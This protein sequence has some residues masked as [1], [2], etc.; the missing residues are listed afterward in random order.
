MNEQQKIKSDFPSALLVAAR[1]GRLGEHRGR[2]IS[3]INFK[4]MPQ[5]STGIFIIENTF[6]EKGG[7][8]RHPGGS[9]GSAPIR[10]WG[11]NSTSY[12]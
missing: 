12:K 11:V 4:I 9:E 10:S 3:R 8:A 6:R 5:D 7:P 1:Q 2:G